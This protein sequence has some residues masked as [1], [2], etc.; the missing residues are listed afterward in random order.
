MFD[1]G[2]IQSYLNYQQTIGTT[3]RY[4]KCPF[5]GSVAR[6]GF[7]VTRTPNGF[8]CWCHGCHK[9]YAIG[10]KT[11]PLK[12]CLRTANELKAKMTWSLRKHGK[13]SEQPRDVEKQQTVVELPFDATNEIP[14][15][16]VV[17]LRRYGITQQE[18]RKYGICYSPFYQRVILPVRNA[19]GRLLYWQG[20]YIGYDPNKPK[21]YNISTNRNKV[22]FDTGGDYKTVVLV[23]DILSAIAIARTEQVRAIALLGSNIDDQLILKLRTEGKQVCVWLDLDKRCESYVFSRRLDVFGIRAKTIVTT[24]DPKCYSVNSII[25]EVSNAYPDFFQ[26]SDFDD[27]FDHCRSQQPVRCGLRET[28]QQRHFVCSQL[29]SQCG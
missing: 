16:G 22:W 2:L 18:V 10:G 29:F 6:K 19:A 27:D 13:P 17:W 21:Y 15:R 5:C 20:R 28:L 25:K 4:G 26:D 11:P 12:D 9:S 3:V 8:V 7:V 24:L 1:R 23:E 14:T